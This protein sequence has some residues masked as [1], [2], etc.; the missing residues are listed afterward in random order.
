MKTPNRSENLRRQQEVC[1]KPGDPSPIDV[2]IRA[3]GWDDPGKMDGNRRAGDRLGVH[4]KT[5]GIWR[6]AK[7]YPTGLRLRRCERFL[8]WAVEELRRLG[9]IRK[10]LSEVYPGAVPARAS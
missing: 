8:A 5:V 9:R 4:A 3:L 2:A 7:S 10:S 1:G 6:D